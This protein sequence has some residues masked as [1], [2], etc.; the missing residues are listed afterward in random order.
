MF[1][2]GESNSFPKADFC[3]AFLQLL[4]IKKSQ[5][6]YLPN[7]ALSPSRTAIISQ[8]NDK[9]WLSNN[10]SLPQCVRILLYAKGE[11]MNPLKKLGIALLTIPTLI[12]PVSAQ[13]WL[14][15]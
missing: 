5:K 11:V 14:M 7:A 8:F 9:L 4:C 12:A 2:V 10:I 3:R 1:R 15:Q 6:S 13:T